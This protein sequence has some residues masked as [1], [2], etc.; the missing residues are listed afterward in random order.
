MMD[1]GETQPPVPKDQPFPDG[2]FREVASPFRVS[3]DGL[4]AEVTLKI[5]W[6]T[7][8]N[9]YRVDFRIPKNVRPGPSFVAVTCGSVTGPSVRVEVR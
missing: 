6:P 4:P 7:L 2:P 9:R 1:L 5:G 3:V 8:V